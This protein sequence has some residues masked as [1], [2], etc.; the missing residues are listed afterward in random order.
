M[1]S[2]QSFYKKV[3]KT[4]DSKLSLVALMDIFTIMVFFLLLNSGDSA[5]LENAR[6]VELPDSVTGV[7]AIPEFSIYIDGENI[8]AEDEL[9]VTTKEVLEMNKPG[10]IPKLAE[11]LDDFRAEQAALAEMIENETG[12]ALEGGDTEK[13]VDGE[14][15]AVTILGERTIPFTLLKSVMMTCRKQAFLNVSLALNHVGDAPIPPS[16]GDQINNSN[17]LSVSG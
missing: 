9:V 3:K 7:E 2:E 14:E 8:W 10:V 13:V 5:K 11:A 16:E 15:L 4:P 1:L 6:F 12:V 17:A